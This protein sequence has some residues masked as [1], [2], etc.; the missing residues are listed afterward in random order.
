MEH[1]R[2]MCMLIG[3]S[4]GTKN[5]GKATYVRSSWNAHTQQ[6]RAWREGKG[7]RRMHAG[8]KKENTHV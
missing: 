8:V 2:C 5:K 4:K 1:E 7:E 3:Y 6:R